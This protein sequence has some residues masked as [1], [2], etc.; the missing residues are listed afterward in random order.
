MLKRTM[1]VPMMRLHDA[2]DGS[3]SCDARKVTTVPTQ[4]LAV[5]NGSFVRK[6]AERLARRVINTVG[7][8]RAFRGPG[9]KRVFTLT[10]NREPTAEETD[11]AV[12]FVEQQQGGL[13]AENAAAALTSLCHVLLMTNEFFYVD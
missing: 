1:P 11:W 6:Q 2:P 13:R 7:E 9:V 3:F 12:A 10:V 5:W 8:E 4:I